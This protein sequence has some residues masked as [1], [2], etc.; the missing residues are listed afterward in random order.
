MDQYQIAN[1]YKDLLEKLVYKEGDRANFMT[2]GKTTVKQCKANYTKDYQDSLQK[3]KSCLT[4]N[5][6]KTALAKGRRQYQLVL[7]ALGDM[8]G[9]R[10]AASKIWKNVKQKNPNYKNMSDKDLK[11]KIDTEIKKELSGKGVVGGAKKGEKNPNSK[12]QCLRDQRA[13]REKIKQDRADCLKKARNVKV[14]NAAARA[15]R[16]KKT[17]KKN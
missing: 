16:K 4:Q 15:A 6:K 10:A 2:G 8:K 11:K 17:K 13:R 12:A 3:K 7:S 9:K 5:K 14:A 1:M